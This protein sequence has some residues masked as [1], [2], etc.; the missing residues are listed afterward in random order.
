[1]AE[2]A[3]VPR[4]RAP[5][6]P[7][8]G[9]RLLTPLAFQ[10]WDAVG[11]LGQLVFT[12]RVVLQWI[13]S[14]RAKRSV[15]PLS[16]WS[17]S[18]FGAVALTVYFVYREDPVFLA[19]SLISGCLYARNWWMMARGQGAAPRMRNPWG[20]LVL[21]LLIFGALGAWA[22]AKGAETR[23][24]E[25]A[26]EWLAVGVFGQAL[27]SS[28]F[29]VQWYVSERIGRSVLPASFFWISIVG[30]IASFLYALQPPVDWVQIAAYALNPIPYARN[31]V[32]LA[33][34]RRES[35]RP[36]P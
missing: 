9:P 17:W 14:E 19:G 20:P 18:L 13:A 36:A 25:V 15:V 30:A 27:W 34:E 4:D 35:A 26:W 5:P 33:R 12:I 31:L 28:R 23:S 2:P 7:A 1:V 24:G 22:V 6:G 21:G 8:L 32:L 10:V 16:F 11:W 3:H 29:V